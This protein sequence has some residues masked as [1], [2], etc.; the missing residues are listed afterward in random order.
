MPRVFWPFRVA[1]VLLRAHLWDGLLI[2][3]L[4]LLNPRQT[5]VE[6]SRDGVLLD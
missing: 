4:K 6:T 2:K 1:S 3:Q 5:I